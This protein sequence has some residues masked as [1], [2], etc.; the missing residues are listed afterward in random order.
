MLLTSPIANPKRPAA[1]VFAVCLALLMIAAAR[2]QA[3]EAVLARNGKALLPIR[4]A[5]DASEPVRKLAATLAH[6]LQR[7]SGARFEVKTGLSKAGV[8]LR[9]EAPARQGI[10]DR[11]RYS[12]R[13]H[14]KG[15]V[16]TGT[17]PL[18]L[19]HAAWDLLHR[20][21][22]RQFFPGRT[23]EVVP[24]LDTV[25]L[26]V[27][28]TESPDFH[29]RRIWYG[30]GTWGYNREPWEDW[31]RKN[32]LGGG[33][34]VRSGHAYGGIISAKRKVFAQHPEY[35]ALIDGERRIRPQAKLC[36]GNPGLRKT[37]VE[38]ANEYFDRNPDADCISMDP[39]DGGGWCECE[40]CRKIGPPSDRALLLA[41]Q[42]ADAVKPRRVGM[43]AYAQHSPPP[44]IRVRP[45]VII[46]VATAFI[47]G[48]YTLD[49]LISGWAAQGATLGIREYYSVHTWDRDL[50]GAARGSNLDYLAKTIPDFHR[51]GARFLNAESSDNWGCNGLGYYFAS[52]VLWDV[53]AAKRRD[54]IVE[55]FLTKA[56]GPAE[57]PMRRFYELIDGSNKRARLVNE[58]LLARMYR[59][60]AAARRLTKP[61]SPQQARIDDLILYTRYVDLFHRYRRAEGEQ[62]QQR[63]EALIRHAYRMRTTMMV[64]SKAV[65]RD[66]AARDSKVSVPAGAAWGAPEDRNPW[67]SSK[68]YSESELV[69]YLR[70]GIDRFR[71]LDLD[72]EP[73]EFSTNLVPAAP[74]HLTG[75]SLGG[76]HRGRG[77][78]AWYTYFEKP[79]EIVLHITGGLIAHY[80]DRGNVRVKVFRLTA[81]KDNEPG[82]EKLVAQDRST[83]PD[84]NQ[85]TVRLPIK[86]PGLYRIELNDGNDL[87]QVTWPAGQPMTVALPLGERPASLSGRWGGYFYVPR[88]VKKIGL[89]V[90]TRGGGLLRPDGKPALDLKD[91][92][93]QF[94]SID[95]SSG[96]DGKLWRLTHVAGQV[97]LANT[98]AYVARSAEELLLP[99]EVVR[100]D[101][102]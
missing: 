63:L 40:P 93:G 25:R 90:N 28:V 51:Q 54:E 49:E 18:A 58:D 42:V 66:V 4:I 11:E 50:P 7:I 41:N 76:A 2:L 21:G 30:F 8:L 71:P 57:E 79:G 68:P 73:R 24:R 62:R 31:V 29:F 70:E 39:S 6:Q 27:N 99:A 15:V 38:Y 35:Y 100:R 1:T 97:R 96:M 37:V 48:G 77:A 59:Q 87:T 22:Y 85:R 86:E 84:G 45:N 16:L 82:S 101:A 20:L 17:T 56:F 81:S 19:E 23:W 34:Q 47:R 44:S 32:R 64:H 74:L 98:P 91:R 33:L 5:A 88:G 80:R 14:D 9:I 55:D 69:A 52:R 13:T 72:F 12:I 92:G 60:L 36:I 75:K 46:N 83:P 89:Y 43:Y 10:L 26:D 78:R 95:V 67:K 102:P 94:V 53:D 65:Y 61:N 3:G